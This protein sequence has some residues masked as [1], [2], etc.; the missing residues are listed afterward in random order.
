MAQALSSVEF[1]AFHARRRPSATAL[2]INGREVS[3]QTFYLEIGQTV[4]VLKELGI[5]QG[6]AIAVDT[7]DFYLHWLVL[8]A[9]DA[10]G[11]STLSYSSAE[12][13]TLEEIL[14]QMDW[15]LCSPNDLPSKAKRLHKMTAQWIDHLRSSPSVTSIATPPFEAN[16]ALRFVKS[17]GTT[18]NMKAMIQTRAMH[19]ARLVR[20]QYHLGFSPKTRYLAV[21]GFSIQGSHLDATLCLRAGGTCV[22]EDRKPLHAS[23][24][25]YGITD[26]LLLPFILN[27]L[28]EELPADFAKSPDL[29]IFILGAHVS[30]RIKNKALHFLAREISES[31]GT[32]ETGAVSRI[33]ADGTGTVIPGV[34]VEIVDENDHVLFSEPGRVR[35][36]SDGCVNGYV[37]DP[38][39]TQKMFRD[40]WFYPGDL[41]IMKDA[42]NLQILAREDEV[43]NINGVKLAPEPLEEKLK[44]ELAIH[45]VCLTMLEDE[46]NDF[47]LQVVIV[48]APTF[49]MAACKPDLARLLPPFISK[50]NIVICKAIERTQTG[51]IQR[52]KVLQI[53][54]E[55]Q[56]AR[57]NKTT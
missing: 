47:T 38:D 29:R 22:Y 24:R 52:H 6:Q 28:L 30:A 40:G 16:A 3:Y 36:Q 39:L 55:R 11:V 27:I 10:L 25:D 50:L 26:V 23:L 7:F 15:V 20:S 45:D 17:S 57:S 33:N 18:G 32:N 14:A 35:I 43:L 41:G 44:S 1:I 19:E 48:P 5:E 31:Y 56:K 46:N 51:K 8:L 21:L 34:Y 2:I 12:I 53:L 42:R 37:F 9:A 13:P 49:D 54:Q 4:A